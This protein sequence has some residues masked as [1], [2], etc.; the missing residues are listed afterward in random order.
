MTGQLGDG[1]T[2]Y[3]SSL[4][5]V[6]GVNGTGYLS[7]VTDITGGGLHTL[8]LK[9]DGTVLAW[10]YNYSGQLG[11]GST[12][13]SYIPFP[14]EVAGLTGI[15]SVVAG[16]SGDHSLALK[17]DGTV[18]AWGSNSDG[19]LGDG[20]T[21]NRPAPVQVA[22][23]GTEGTGFLTGIVSISAGYR[24]S[25]AIKSDGT[26]WAWGDND[27]YQLADGTYTDRY[28]PVQVQR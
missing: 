5:Q 2:T 7:D 28:T 20:T 14:V 23:Q 10:G 18:W 16:A 4:V 21:T 19:Q 15:V 26:V 13:E 24:H 17:S 9:N 3:R 6:L 27:I 25:L 22:G 11:I 8:A 12:T 1:T